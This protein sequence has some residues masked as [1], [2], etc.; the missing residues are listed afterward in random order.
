MLI[1]GMTTLSSP[2]VVDTADSHRHPHHHLPPHDPQHRHHN[3]PTSVSSKEEVDSSTANIFVHNESS[4]SSGSSSSSNSSDIGTEQ[5]LRCNVNIQSPDNGNKNF[6]SSTKETDL[7]S[8]SFSEHSTTSSNKTLTALYD[9]MRVVTPQQLEAFEMLV[10]TPIWIFDFAARQNR[11]ANAAG[12]HLW[13]APD[14]EEFCS[15]DMTD[16][17]ASAIARSQKSQRRIVQGQAVREQWTFYPKG[18]ART[19]RLTITAVRWT[20]QDDQCSMLCVAESSLSSSS[21]SSSCSLPAAATTPRISTITASR[22]HDE[23]SLEEEEKETQR[24]HQPQESCNGNS[25]GCNTTNCHNVDHENE[26][27][28]QEDLFD[29]GYGQEDVINTNYNSPLDQES[30]RVAEIIRHLPTAVC[31]FDLNGQVMFE[32]PA[33]YLPDEDFRQEGE[34]K[35]EEKHHDDDDDD[36][37]LYGRDRSSE[38]ALLSTSNNNSRGSLLHRFVDQKVATEVLLTL[39]ETSETSF[40]TINM[41]AE[42]YTS[43]KGKT[44]WSAIQLRKTLD[45]V[46]SQ[47]VILYSAHDKSDAMEAKREREARIEKSE[48]LAVMAHEIRTPLHQVTGFIDLLESTSVEADQD[49]HETKESKDED[50]ER[51]V[52][53]VMN[54]EQKGYVKLLRSSAETLMTVISDVLDYSKLEAGHM[55]I[56]CIPFEPLSV[57][58]GCMAAVRGS[59]DE[60]GLVLKLVYGESRNLNIKNQNGLPFTNRKTSPIIP[61]RILGD[62]NRLR[63][64]VL[65]LLSN[66]I[67]FTSFGSVQVE[68]SSFVTEGNADNNDHELRRWMHVVVKDTG[69]GISEKNQKT[70]FQKYKQAAVSV[71]R[72]HGGT[73]LGLAICQTLVEKMGGSIGVES[74]IGKGSSFWFT[75]PI[76]TPR[77]SSMDAERAGPSATMKQDTKSFTILVAEDNKINQKLVGNMLKRMGHK[78]TL[79]ENGQLAIDLIKQERNSNSHEASVRRVFDAV[80]MDIQMPVMDGLEA[81]RR[82]RAMGYRDLPILGL[83]AS[84]KRSDYQELGFDDWLPKPILMNDL[85]LKL[86]QIRERESQNKAKTSGTG[87]FRWG[88]SRN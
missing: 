20:A 56:E 41:E 10:N 86:Q 81:T 31:Q 63:Q 48:F 4:M 50:D 38:G 40:A 75:L 54:E 28:E 73:G 87:M 57:M 7:A 60:K 83:T 70:I 44:Q 15:R 77:L 58:Q 29:D 82:L 26:G 24:Q 19:V 72:T 13:N 49:R 59:C 79:V 65:N 9:P 62:P 78:V 88:W 3:L 39:K 5:G 74:E 21:S 36:D 37:F 67:K 34:H 84:M 35:E 61:F 17:S 66:A 18:Q 6:S 1:T 51:Q 14:V 68:V 53:G 45:P 33:A 25:S 69:T 27:K 85:Q 23:G 12:L 52:S 46:T 22:G 76:S 43:Q 71:A 2:S 64:V 42:L 80:L 32:N 11:W 8:L 55:K 30:L 16:M 47:P